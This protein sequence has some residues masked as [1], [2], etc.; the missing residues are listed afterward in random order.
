MMTTRSASYGARATGWAGGG[1]RCILEMVR[2]EEPGGW[3]VCD[4]DPAGRYV[5]AIGAVGLVEFRGGRP[6]VPALRNAMLQ[7]ERFAGSH[8]SYRVERALQ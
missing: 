6:T 5:R 7:L 3:R 2:A 1:S 4:N 8:P